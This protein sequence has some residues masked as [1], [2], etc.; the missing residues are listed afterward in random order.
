MKRRTSIKRISS[1]LGLATSFTSLTGLLEGCSEKKDPVW[2]PL[3]LNKN[4]RTLISIFADQVIPTTDTPSATDAGVPAFIEILMIDV[5]QK[6]D[7]RDLLK[8]LEFF[9]QNCKKDIGHE[10]LE[11][12]P[13]QQ[14]A[15]MH[16]VTNS[17]HINH[18]IFNKMK[19]L[20]VGAYFTSEEGM[21]QNLNYTPIPGKFETCRKIG[22]NAKIMA[23]DRI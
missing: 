12:K 5:F 14:S 17:S 10:F 13:E 1:F 21:K 6:K 7:T 15:W 11:C 23:G 4:Q 9:N 20:V 22:A 3:K 18:T 2:A 8:D 19:D 16:K